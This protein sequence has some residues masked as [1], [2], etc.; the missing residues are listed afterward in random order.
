M[1]HKNRDKYIDLRING[2]LFPSWLVANFKEYKLNEIVL[3]KDDPCH[4]AVNLDL[5]QYQLFVGKFLDFNGPYKNMLLYF[6]LGA[7]K[8]A[9]AIN[10]YNV[11]YNFTP[12]WNVFILLK[13][14]L[15]DNWMRELER[16]LYDEDKQ[17]RKANIIFISYDSPIADK[18]FLD[19]VKKT[20]SS[21]KNLYIIEEAHNFISNV[22]SNISSG[23]GKRAQI[24]YDYIIQDQ[25]ENQDTRVVAL[26][27]TPAINNPFELALLFNLLRPNIFPK[28]ETKFNQEFVSDTGYRSLNPEKKNLFQ[29]SIMG[30]VSY[31][32]GSTP[33]Y[34]ATKTTEYVYV[35]MSS[36]QEDIYGYFEDIEEKQARKKKA[37]QS[38]SETYKSYTRQSCNFVFPYLG[39]GMAG[40]NRPRPKDYAISEKVGQQLD[41]GKITKNDKE[42]KEKYYD[43]QNYVNAIEKFMNTFEHYID[44]HMAN[45]EKEGY[46]I[47]TD[48][49]NCEKNYKFD[50][51]EFNK[52]EEKFSRVY[53]ELYKCSAKMLNM[54]F[55]I[56]KVKGPALVYSN[57][58][59]MEGIQIFK[60]YLKYFG[61][62]SF[63][64]HME[65]QQGKPFYRY[66]EYHGMIEKDIRGKTLERFNKEDNKYG[67]IC[68]IIMISP[69]GA[70][71]LNLYS[72][73]SVH[74]M[75][76]YW[77]EVRIAQMAGRA[78]RL[79][80][81]KF[82][83]M[84]ERNVII[85]RYKSVRGNY[86]DSKWT[87]DQY[88]E[89][90]ARGK[91]G[92]IQSFLDAIKEAAVDC[93]LYKNHNMMTQDYKCFQFD[94]VSLF[95]E[96]IGP[97][98]KED[99][100]DNMKINNGSNSV[101]SKSVR[102]KVMK[103]QAVKQLS[104]TPPIKYSEK[105][106]YWYY[107]ESGVVYDY[108]LYFAVGKVARDDK[109]IPKKLDKD[110]YIIDKL[111]PIP[112]IKE[113]K[114]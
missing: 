88:I 34:F 35:K 45:D 71:G 3:D 83:P 77:H 84:D 5:K 73:R 40:E 89:D 4:K 76:P 96:Q 16:F 100:S 86:P 87:T 101:N 33:D 107:P 67:E 58:V 72:V 37:K 97:A 49:E 74:I 66:T 17:Q 18:T 50:F 110:T 80:S 109:D 23:T 6:G 79:C 8:T 92:L 21:K 47:M 106:Y 42:T 1:S 51:A 91:E 113:K 81:H 15:K 43:S 46:T 25:L 38:S 12:G 39:Q 103:I 61:F 20:D 64:I 93:V 55:N 63:D 99:M 69:A 29:R 95:D 56:I 102:I 41:K 60:I 36:Y 24:I 114:E 32:I 112:I 68:K 19:E 104:N 31:Y 78:M 82:L 62:S 52:K 44:E 28:S 54:I 105:E 53:Q 13:A 7:G 30:L 108:D 14:T 85:Y 11:L 59:L 90:M 27:G 48:I 57:Y 65:K 9:T 10:L 26:S 94:E 111:I 22:V 2:R 70:E 75:E 98:Y